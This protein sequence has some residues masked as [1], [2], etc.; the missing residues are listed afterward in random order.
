MCFMRFTAR[1]IWYY[2]STHWAPSFRAAVAREGVSVVGL[3]GETARE[4]SVP[5][6]HAAARS[7]EG[8]PV[9]VY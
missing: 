4:R 8:A 9:G 3:F 6:R 7:G 2:T 1:K 5:Q